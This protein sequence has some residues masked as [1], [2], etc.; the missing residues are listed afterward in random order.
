MIS[1]IFLQYFQILK[2]IL[3]LIITIGFC[4][5]IIHERLF[6]MESDQYVTKI[7]SYIKFAIKS[8]FS[9]VN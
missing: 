4:F 2:R 7:I 3:Y 6:I 9:I 1:F 5:H 8:E